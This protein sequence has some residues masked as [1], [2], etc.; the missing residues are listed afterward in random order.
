MRAAADVYGRERRHQPG[1]VQKDL[2]G[3][4]F[5]QR[6]TGGDKL[7]AGGQG[8][9]GDLN[10]RGRSDRSRGG[11]GVDHRT[12][13]R[14][15]IGR[16]EADL[17]ARRDVAQR[18]REERGAIAARD[19]HGQRAR[20][21]GAVV[22][23]AGQMDRGQG[24]VRGITGQ[25]GAVARAIGRQ[26]QANV[27]DSKGVAGCSQNLAA[28]GGCC[29]RLWPKERAFQQQRTARAQVIEQIGR[30]QGAKVAQGS[31]AADGLPFFTQHDGVALRIGGANR[32]GGLQAV[33][34]RVGVGSLRLT[35]LEPSR[36]RFWRCVSAHQPRAA[37]G[38]R[39]HAGRQVVRG[40]VLLRQDR[41]IQR[42]Q[43]ERGNPAVAVYAIDH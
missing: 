3:G 26:R 35:A 37:Q 38:Q 32:R 7:G 16:A 42:D 24:I 34:N 27:A 10:D 14:R 22:D 2:Q 25:V 28:A 31:A 6:N 13:G 43:H 8:G 40:R 23:G 41:T 19:R 33:E 11:C 20:D 30:V 29:G 5:A 36:A 39:F 21:A 17:R 12:G 15:G 18:G 4:G 9:G 1:V